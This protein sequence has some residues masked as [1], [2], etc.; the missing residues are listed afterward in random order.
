MSIFPRRINYFAWQTWLQSVETDQ[1]LP[2]SSGAAVQ[3]SLQICKPRTYMLLKRNPFSWVTRSQFSLMPLSRCFQTAKWS[4]IFHTELLKRNY[5]PYKIYSAVSIHQRAGNMQQLSQPTGL[6]RSLT[7]SL[8]AKAPESSEAVF[9]PRVLSPSQYGLTD[10]GWNFLYAKHTLFGYCIWVSF[11]VI[12]VG[13]HLKQ[14]NRL[15]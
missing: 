5:P 2:P 12:V 14:C 3:R 4:Q 6:S 1:V 7:L 15:I 10:W 9:F 8:L 11:L 13:V